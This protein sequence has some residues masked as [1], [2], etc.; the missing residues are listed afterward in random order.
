MTTDVDT[1]LARVA[2]ATVLNWAPTVAPLVPES[3][4]NSVILA[5]PEDL[6]VP[7]L[8]RLAEFGSPAARVWATSL[9][10]QRAKP[11]GAQHL[12]RLRQDTSPVE[13][14]TCLVGYRRVCDWAR[15]VDSGPRRPRVSRTRLL[16]LL[17]LVAALAWFAS[18]LI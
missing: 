11:I 5:A 6:V 13:I 2:S 1:A 17:L 15:S 18:E 8:S 10:L 3:S 4:P 14:N 7:A 9:L 16:A 12:A